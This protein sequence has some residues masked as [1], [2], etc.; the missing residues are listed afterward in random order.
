MGPLPNYLRLNPDIAATLRVSITTTPSLHTFWEMLYSLDDQ[1]VQS[2][3]NKG[4][5][6]RE[7]HELSVDKGKGRIQCHFDSAGRDTT[8]PRLKPHRSP[9]NS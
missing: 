5:G 2:S 1:G 3:I 4:A 6:R 7:I 8:P 9:C